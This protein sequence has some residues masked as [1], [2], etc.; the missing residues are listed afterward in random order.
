MTNV[1][2]QSFIISVFDF[3][4]FILCFFF[5]SFR[6]RPP[7]FSAD[8]IQLLSVSVAL[9][10]S[11]WLCWLIIFV[12]YINP[13]WILNI[14]RFDTYIYV[15]V[16]EWEGVC[17]CETEWSLC[18]CNLG[19]ENDN[20]EYDGGIAKKKTYLF[21]FVC[22]IPLYQSELIISL[23]GTLSVSVTIHCTLLFA[24]H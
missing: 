7:S 15:C 18:E 4:S 6:L 21:L 10:L 19:D 2:S 23:A 16:F 17:V 1:R 5:L 22:Y 9:V 13:I 14:G 24:I 11:V 20:C 12:K 3:F 8:L